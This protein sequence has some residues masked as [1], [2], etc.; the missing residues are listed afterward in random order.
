ME[1]LCMEFS[2]AVRGF[3]YYEKYWDPVESECLKCAHEK[4]NPYDHFTIM[5]CQK[6]GKIVG[7]LPM[8]IS[9]P[10]KYLLDRGPRI[11]VTLPSTSY[12]AFLLVQ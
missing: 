5:T 3:H 11:T 4:E 9:Q 2:T 1:S 12:Y 10:T 8:E 7:P 6:D